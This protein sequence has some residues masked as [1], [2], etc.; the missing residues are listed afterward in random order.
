VAGTTS[1][2]CG[3]AAGLAIAMEQMVLKMPWGNRDAALRIM[4]GRA[5]KTAGGRAAARQ[6]C[7]V[8]WS[9]AGQA[10]PEAATEA[11]DAWTEL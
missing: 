11:A 7:S 9:T 2:D 8:P 3:R 10:G 5:G 4:R 6:V 1:T